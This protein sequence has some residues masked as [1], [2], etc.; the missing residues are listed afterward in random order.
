MTL[1]PSFLK[2][3][4]FLKIFFCILMLIIIFDKFLIMLITSGYLYIK[5]LM[6]TNEKF[7]N[8]ELNKFETG[9]QY[10][11]SNIYK[12]QKYNLGYYPSVKVDSRQNFFNNNKFLPECCNYY[13]DYSSDRGCPC[14]TPE[15][16]YY[17]QS[18]GTNRSDDSFISESNIKNI[19]FSPT[20]A[21]KGNSDKVFLNH[22][23]YIEKPN[24]L[25]DL[26]MNT[27]LLNIKE[28]I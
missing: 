20:N 27:I 23:K 1:M 16:Q 6:K 7:N 12:N 14:I 21:F 17:L 13:S 26:C 5:K 4:K 19:Y 2:N 9:L 11:I 25:N 15:Q 24:T 18:R 10:S 22:D 8:L 28:P 3:N